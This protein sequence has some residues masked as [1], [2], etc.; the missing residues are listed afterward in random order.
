MG[1]CVER[2]LIMRHCIK[3]RS[4]IIFGVFIEVGLFSEALFVHFRRIPTVITKYVV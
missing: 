3:G 1:D 4:G 2:V